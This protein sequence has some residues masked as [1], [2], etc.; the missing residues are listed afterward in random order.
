MLVLVWLAAAGMLLPAA[1]EARRWDLLL[2]GRKPAAISALAMTLAGRAG[3]A[4]S[5]QQPPRCP[6]IKAP[7]GPAPTP[8]F[9]LLAERSGVRHVC[10]TRR[11]RPFPS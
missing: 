10:T 3:R 1:A 2:W 9:L 8:R 7:S 5:K 4:P 6:W 11:C